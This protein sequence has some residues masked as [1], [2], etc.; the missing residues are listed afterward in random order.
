MSNKHRTVGDAAVP[1]AA[2]SPTPDAPENTAPTPDAPDTG[3][4]ADVDA[5]PPAT[6]VVRML[7]R[8]SGYRNGEEW[9][10][11]GETIELPRV[12]ADALIAA[13]WARSA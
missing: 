10:G 4:M 2:A 11:A 12:E 7:Y 3:A 1:P 13:G 5:D 6:L 9:P 8:I